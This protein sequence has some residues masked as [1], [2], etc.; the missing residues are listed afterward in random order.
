MCLLYSRGF[1]GLRD[2]T[3][4]S[5]FK[6]KLSIKWKRDMIY[7]LYFQ[8]IWF[9]YICWRDRCRQGFGSKFSWSGWEKGRIFFYFFQPYDRK[10]S[11]SKK[12]FSNILL[13]THNDLFKWLIVGL[14]VPYPSKYNIHEKTFHKMNLLLQILQFL[15]T[16]L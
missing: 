11:F 9:C 4:V 16:I 2:R 7:Y 6:P 10:W 3:I 5:P 8:G 1:K 12:L 15:N 13:R 14:N